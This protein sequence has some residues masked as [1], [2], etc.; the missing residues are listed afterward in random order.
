M[1]SFLTLCYLIDATNWPTNQ[2]ISLII[3]TGRQIKRY[4][5]Y[6]SVYMPKNK[7]KIN[8]ILMN[9]LWFLNAFLALFP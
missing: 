5:N 6:N 9:S 2:E 7:E 4:D 8:S 3:V 1:Q